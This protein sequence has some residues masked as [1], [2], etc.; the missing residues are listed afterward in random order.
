MSS[1]RERLARLSPERLA[2]LAAEL[3]DRLDRV[4][5]ETA[6][7]REPIAVIGIGCRFPG[8]I[9]GPDAFWD[10]LARGGDAVTEVPADRWDVDG[11]YDPDPDRPG[12][13]ATRWGSFLDDVAGFDADFFGIAPREAVSLDPQQ[14]LLLE[15]VWHALEHAQLP[16]DR[17][18]GSDTGVFIGL[19]N[20]DYSSL[21]LSQPYERFDMYLSSGNAGSMA[22]GR[23]AYAFGFQ[24]PALVVDTACS[25]S[26]VA[27][28]LAVESLRRGEC[29]TAVAGGASLILAP[30]TMI[31]LTKA[32]ML[33][34]DGRCRT[35]DAEAGGIVRGEGV[36]MVVLK[37]LSDARADG[38]RILAVVRGS[39]MNQDGRSSGITAPNGP[40]QEALMRRALDNA[41]LAPHDV[42]YIEAHGTGTKLGDPIEVR[43][44]A[45]V[46]AQDRDASDPLRIGS[47]KTN[48]GHTEASA[49]VA[50]FIKAVLALRNGA[51]PP[52]LHLRER[53]PLIE[54]DQWP[55]EVP[56]R[57]VPWNAAPRRAAV[58]SFGF[59]GTNAHVILE[60]YAD[61]VRTSHATAPVL[62]LPLSARS[63]AALATLAAR[64][65][66][67]LRAA[68]ADAAALT[69]AAATSRAQLTH[70]L[71]V[72]G[73][74]SNQL[75]DALEAYAAGRTHNAAAA[76]TAAVRGGG[77]VVFLFTGQG[78]QAPGMGRELYET[79]APYRAALDRCAELLRP[80]MDVPLLDLLHPPPGNEARAAELLANTAYTQPA[81]FAVEYALAETWRAWGIRPAVVMGHSLG[82]YVAATVAG[83]FTLEDGLRL[84]AERG[85][86]MQSLPAGGAMAAVHAPFETIEPRARAAGLAIAAINGPAATVV[87]GRAD[88]VDVLVK[89]LQTENIQSQPLAVSHAFHSPLVEPV[90]GEFE[91]IVRSLRFGELEVPLVS[92]LTGGFVDRE[93]LADPRYWVRHMREPV[94]FAAGVRALSDAGHTRYLEVGPHPTLIGMASACLD[95]ATA[96]WL[97]SLRRGQDAWTTMLGALGRLWVGGAAIDWDAVHD[98]RARP[99][100]TLPSYPF[101]HTR[102]WPDDLAPRAA[103][104]TSSEWEGWLWQRAWEPVPERPVPPAAPSIVASRLDARPHALVREHGADVYDHLLPRLDALCAAF[105]TRALTQLGASFRAGDRIEEADLHGRL[106]IRPQ[107]ARLAQRMMAMLEEDGIVRRRGA[108]W[109]VTGEL[110]PD[111]DDAGRML[112]ADFPECAAEID[113]TIHCGRS[114]GDVLRGDQDAMDVLFPGGSLAPTERLYSE[115]PSFRAFNALLAEAVT[116]AIPSTGTV[117]ILE[118]GAGTGGATSALLPHLPAGRTRYAFTDVS[119]VFLPNARTR[120]ARYDFIEF[121]VLDIARD[122]AVQ[123][124]D[125]GGYDIII[126]SNVLHATPDLAATLANVRRLLAPGGILLALEGLRPQRF[127]DL[128]VGLT[129]GWWSFE[130]SSLRDYALLDENRWH[131]ILVE[132]GFDDVR[133]LP[134]S[135]AASRGA[136]GQQAVI[137]A[138]APGTA[139]AAPRRWVA[140][141][142]ANGPSG[143]VAEDLKA[144][145][146]EIEV[147]SLEHALD[148]RADG[149]LHLLALDPQSEDVMEAQRALTG[150]AIALA[151]SLAASDRPAQLVF[152]TSGA[153]HIRDGDRVQPSAAP[154]WGLGRTLAL[155]H[156]ELRVRLIDIDDSN[157]LADQLVHDGQEDELALRDARP[158]RA[159]VRAAE[160]AATDAAIEGAWIVTGGLAGLGLRC[161]QWLAQRGATRIVLNAR[162]HP[163]NEALAAIHALE[164]NGI[165]VETVIGDVADE[166]VAEA[167]VAA[168]GPDRLMGVLHAAGVTDDVAFMKLDWDR[169]ARVMRA[170]VAGAWRLHRATESLPLRHFVLFSSAAA[171]LGSPGQ[172]N[173]AAANAYLSGLAWHRKALGLPALTIDWGP[174]TDTGAATRGDTLERARAAGLAPIEP[175]RGLAL[176]GRL[177]GSDAV[178]VAAGKVDWPAFLAHLPNGV[179]PPLFESVGGATA[180]TA[181]APG[182][183]Q[184]SG[185][186][187]RRWAAAGPR[188]RI[189]LGEEITALAR[190][191][192]GLRPDQP[193]DREVPLSQIGLDSLMAVELRNA[194]ARGVDRPLPATLLFNHPTIEEL[195]ACLADVLGEPAEPQLAP[196]GGS[197]SDLEALSEDEIVKLLERK[198][199]DG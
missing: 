170:K 147:R 99:A 116:A 6:R 168:A 139:A 78:A 26:L 39:A 124:F 179:R 71:A 136:L 160:P 169:T 177:M 58:S 33:A 16:P 92:N 31:A 43:A 10:F 165:E 128:T 60:S 194:L 13:M 29:R 4:E 24:G 30:D 171:F 93:T 131:R 154:L 61:E 18:E 186:L 68:D 158:W 76:G 183:E 40:A 22:A 17:I 193:L 185:T 152:V 14:R 11:L 55:I 159:R 72:T 120:F 117:R 180:T 199:A 123:G 35:F 57:L 56:D 135:P 34:P 189:V 75:A 149:I 176:L 143:R 161:A 97:P 27:L 9:D 105:V 82:E 70:R 111:A 86:L 85:R 127:G 5:A 178:H 137:L 89:E 49:G 191:V 163:S 162:S 15:V 79:C 182:T 77:R 42:G 106:G 44:L 21:L 181:G 74:D 125:A 2:L 80:L 119:P 174:W 12:T 195:T 96:T 64:Y 54:W 28:H 164:Q 104:A 50:G 153:R 69:H 73:T 140:I 133:T 112:L 110:P 196:A 48:F 192:L 102:Y 51:L 91:R 100:I 167:L 46:Y 126:A 157:G 118:V 25:S 81:L 8:G 20:H 88:A 188:R 1:F 129:P 53:N 148:A 175:E 151:R 90:L 65:A 101:Q 142:D 130:D 121:K 173:H 156:P 132:T 3:K 38:D 155:E 32:H 184:E 62:L 122:P 83:L 146:I 23:I 172:A 67:A 197:P 138:R 109:L 166:G 150:G 113:L 41:G 59:S 198:L 144:K 145:G 114:L 66:E 115:A 45:S 87:S 190:R 19:C 63:P 36:G 108:G 7:A 141:A 84:A 103:S 187:V 47:V 95:D 107:H 94:R 134:A 37:R 98:H 52:H